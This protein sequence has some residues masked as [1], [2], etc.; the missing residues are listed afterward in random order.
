[1]HV[2]FSHSYR[3]VAIN[4]YFLRHFVR[5]D[6]PLRADQKSDTWCVAKLERYLFEASGFISVI[7]RRPNDQDAAAYSAYIG[8]ELDLARRARIPRLLF[9]DQQVLERHV[10][11]F[12]QDVV[13]FDAAAPQ[14]HDE[15]HRNA[16]AAFLESARF[17]VPPL[18]GLR[19]SDQATLVIDESPALRRVGDEV[20]ELLRRE[21]FSV[22]RQTPN[23]KARAIDDV[24]LLESLWRSELCV[25]LLGERLSDVH[26]ALAMAYAHF[27]PVLRLQHDKTAPDCSPTMQGTIRW[28]S[29]P[30]L[31]V[32]FRRQLGAFRRG[33][34][35]PVEMARGE[36]ET[37][38]LRTM[39]T[40]LWEASDANLWD[41]RDGPA[42]VKHVAVKEGTVQDAVNRAR[43]LAQAAHSG[44]T[45]RER[46]FDL[47]RVLYDELKSRRYAY[48]IEPQTGTRAGVQAIR[49]PLQIANGK[50]AT[51][52]DL[53][54][55]FAALFEAAGLQALIVVVRTATM[56]HALPG[57]RAEGEPAW[58]QPTLGDLRRAVT[59]GDAVFLEGTGAVE[60]D[61]PVTAEEGNSRVE[62]L[63][64][65][66]SARDVA[67]RLIQRQDLELVHFVD[68]RK[69]RG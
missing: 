41:S 20:A 6:I 23:R 31:L 42:L 69:L 14:L 16:I 25:F 68:V 40:G 44:L 67:E 24:R 58:E 10:T 56:A 48:E 60:A 54:C 63:L 52:I 36:N 5:K 26:L 3:D 35:E 13:A 17:S 61:S 32:E 57:Y 64:D 59:A 22:T 2:F 37:A 18:Q 21:G 49:W 4:S 30:D 9:V 15:Q 28:H 39:G 50:A 12:P 65:F 66:L 33:F 1:M 45:G 43:R 8:H 29:E 38:A 11:R 19:Q 7:T 47:S 53:A 51:C 55:L 62:K 34:V 46:D 27:I